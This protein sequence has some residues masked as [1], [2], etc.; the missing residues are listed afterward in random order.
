M[1]GTRLE[2]QRQHMAFA[3]SC[4]TRSKPSPRAPRLGPA[5]DLV[6]G[7]TSSHGFPSAWSMPD[8][9]TKSRSSQSLMVGASLATG[10]PDCEIPSNPALQRPGECQPL[11]ANVRLRK[12]ERC[13]LKVPWTGD[14][15]ILCLTEGPLC[16]EHLIPEALGGS[17][18]TEFLCLSCN[19]R[20]GHALE[21]TAKLDPSILLAANK[22]AG[23]I[24]ALAKR[25]IEGHAHV[26]HS[27]PGPAPG[28]IRNGEFRAKSRILED[29]SLVQSTDDARRSVVTILRK[30][31]YEEAPIQ[32]AIAAFDQAPENKRVEIA[33]G[34][35]VVK[36]TVQRIELD[37]SRTQLMNPLIPAK[38]A[39]E[40]LACHVGT[41][42]YGDAPQLSEV[43]QALL[44]PPQETDAIR[45]ERL[46]SNKYEPFHGI[47]FEGN[48]PYAQVQIRLFGWLAFRVHFLRLA[49]GGPRFV[50]T[51][52]LD[53]GEERVDV[54]DGRHQS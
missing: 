23:A 19:S 25:L 2:V 49:V 14:R 41:A 39:F 18:T 26:G 22:L 44:V 9:M 33:P 29:G 28:F 10:G 5:T 16:E 21:A 35:E 47:C 27:K 34:L 40:F 53:T 4:G 31:G 32:K 8:V 7:T 48:D 12:E 37:L 11:T 54:I 43:R 20:L 38:T 24:P 17:L 51:Q 45:V 36:W 15:C 52:R 1:T 6:H 42:I 46:S 13:Y 30:S 50:Y 3:T